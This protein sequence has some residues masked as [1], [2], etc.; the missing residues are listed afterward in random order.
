MQQPTQP[1]HAASA[2]TRSHTRRWVQKGVA[3]AVLLQQQLPLLLL[4][5]QLL[6]L[7]RGLPNEDGVAG[8]HEHLVDRHLLEHAQRA[9]SAGALQQSR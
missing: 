4:L 3:S 5:L 9:H 6:L 2:A 1:P 7:L 8:V